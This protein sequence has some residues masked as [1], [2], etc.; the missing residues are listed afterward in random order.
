LYKTDRKEIEELVAK[1]TL[2]DD[3]LMSK[4]FEYNLAATTLVLRIVLQNDKIRAISAKGQSELKNPIVGGRNIRLD[5][6]AEDETG[7]QYNIEVQRSNKGAD[8]RRARYHSASLDV[9]MLSKGVP[10]NEL[11]ESYV[12]FITENDYFG[13]GK[14]IYKIERYIEDSYDKVNDGSHIIYINGSYVGDD[15]IGK[16]IHDFKCKKANDMY[17]PELSDG[18]RQFKEEGGSGSMCELIEKFGNECKIEGRLEGKI[19]GEIKATIETCKE[20]GVELEK[21]VSKISVKFNITEEEA[22]AKV[23]EYWK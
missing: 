13:R 12:I 16:L 17:Y 4:V 20:L 6:L 5:I 11:N 9:R 3:D 15:S 23:E 8:V 1:L 22:K 19:E 21:V 14:P 18:V 7:K 10:F 2:F